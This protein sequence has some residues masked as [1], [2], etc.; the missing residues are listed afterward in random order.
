MLSSYLPAAISNAAS[1]Q[2]MRLRASFDCATWLWLAPGTAVP[3]LLLTPPGDGS[4]RVVA[5]VEP[6]ATSP[7]AMPE[8]PA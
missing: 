1:E 2:P 4:E 5:V 3:D 8:A 6:C 7:E